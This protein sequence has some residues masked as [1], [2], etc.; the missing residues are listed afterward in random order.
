MYENFE[1]WFNF[2][3]VMF[4]ISFMCKES[5]LFLKEKSKLQ[6]DT[7]KKENINYNHPGKFYIPKKNKQNTS[8][9][10]FGLD[11]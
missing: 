11:S 10:F 1:K 5:P 2:E 3:W 7:E 9:V 6:T 8:K 4:W